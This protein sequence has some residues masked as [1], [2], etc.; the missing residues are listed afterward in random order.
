M[1][2]TFA[3]AVIVLVTSVSLGVAAASQAPASPYPVADA[4]AKKV[5]QKYQT[6]TCQQLLAEKAQTPNPQQV[7]T[8][9]KAIQ[10]LRQDPGMRKAFLD[11]VAAPIVNKMFECGMIP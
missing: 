3:L 9:Q 8:E 10:M 11:Q 6:I 1:N 2:R 7:Q 5:I 4:I